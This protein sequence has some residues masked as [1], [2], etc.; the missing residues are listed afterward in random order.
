MYV[1]NEPITGGVTLPDAIARALKYNYAAELARQ[2][3][4]L[5]ERQVDL[6]MGA[7]LPRLALNAGYTARSHD[8]AAKSVNIPGHR[9]SQD[10]TY[11]QERTHFTAG[12]EFIWSVIDVG[13]GYLQAKQ[14][15]YQ[16]LAAVERH[17]RVIADVVKRVQDSYWKAQAAARVLHRLEPL[18]VRA[19]QVL[20]A[21]RTS[22][23]RNLAPEMQTL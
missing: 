10:W 22:A 15:G 19:E 23:R 11:S 5:N 7:M 1:N 14:Q 16:A 2:Q 12:P 21:S 3:A 6:A 13:I 4:T 9:V 20:E 17:R 8:P 18:I